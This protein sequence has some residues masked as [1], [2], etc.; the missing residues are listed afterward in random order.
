MISRYVPPAVRLSISTLSILLFAGCAAVPPVAQIK[1]NPRFEPEKFFAGHTR[2]SGI[3]ENRIGKSQQ[4]FST[5]AAGQL[6]GN[7]LTL[8]QTF[9]Y[10]DGRTQQRQWQIRRLDAHRYEGTAN[11]VVGYAHGTIAGDTFRFS[12]TVALKPGNPFFTVRLEQVMTL[13]G[14]GT[15]ENRATISKFGLTL[16]DVT[17]HFRQVD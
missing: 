5:D 9:R 14:D 15:V 2:S 12:Y 16:S 8:H 11:D 13:R 3:F 17:E 10:E 7:L 6:R 1:N 4:R